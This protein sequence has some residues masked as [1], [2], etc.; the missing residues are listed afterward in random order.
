MEEFNFNV[1]ENTQERRKKERE[2]QAAMVGLSLLLPSA[3]V[4]LLFAT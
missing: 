4:E 2:V 1:I 3:I